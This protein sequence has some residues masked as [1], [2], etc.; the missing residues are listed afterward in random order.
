[1]AYNPY[2]P[3]GAPSSGANSS[4]SNPYISAA[5]AGQ[6]RRKKE[7]EDRQTKLYNAEALKK[8]DEKKKNDSK[9]I[10]DKAGSAIGNVAKGVGHFAHDAVMD[11][12][13]TT[14]D[15]WQGLGDV[16]RGELAGHEMEQ[17]TEQRNANTKEWS[18]YM[19]T[20]KTEDWKKPEVK[21]KLKEFSDK[22]KGIEVSQQ[23]KDDMA[24]EQ[25][26]DSKKLAFDTAQTFL[27]VA[28]AGVGDIIAAP[29]ELGAKMAIKTA[30]KD[31]I[32]TGGTEVLEQLIKEGGEQAAKHA[33][34]QLLKDGSKAAV[35][36]VGSKLLKSAGKDALLGSAF[37]VTST[38]SNNPNATAKDYIKAAAIG[39]VVGGAIPV[40][41]T[42]L[43]GAKTA[44]TER[45]ATKAA[46]RS[47]TSDVER[48]AKLTPEGYAKE[49]GVSVEAAKTEQAALATSG[50]E[51]VDKGIKAKVRNIFTPIKNLG[52]RTQSSFEKSAGGYHVAEAKARAV[53]AQIKDAAESAGVK[54]DMN[55][56]HDIEAGTAPKNA[57][58]QQFREIA[59]KAR[60]EGLDAGLDIGHRENYVPH[61]WKQ[62]AEQVDKIARGAG[63]K[64][65]AEGERIIPT[66][67]EGLKLGLKPKYTDPAKMMGEYVKNIE[68]T[69]TN[70]ALLT[71][72]KDQGLL[73]SG[74]PPAG[75]KTISA[76]GFPRT[77]QGNQLAAPRQMAHILDNLYGR[78][79]SIIDKALHKTAR[80]N[81]IWQDIALAGG[82]PHTPANFFTFS[83]AIKEAALGTGQVVTGS[84][85]QGA[86]TI[87]SPVAAFVRSFSDKQTGKVIKA[88]EGFLESLAK[89]GAPINFAET[90]VSRSTKEFARDAVRW[91]KLFNEPTFGRFMPNLQLNTAKNVQNALE[92]KLGREAALD[93]T[94]DIMKKMYGITD[95]LATGRSQAVQDAIGTVAFAPKYRESIVNVLANTVKSLNPA[96]YGDRAYSLNRRLAVGMGVTY[97]IYDQLNRLATGH[98]IGANP[99]GK[100]LQLA[101]PYGGKDD[102]GNQKVVYIP[103]MPSFMTLP[104]AAVGAVSGLVHGDE[105]AVTSEAGKLLSMPVQVISQLASNKDYFGRP[106]T[107]DE[108][109]SK[110]SGKPEDSFGQKWLKR[111]G[112]VAG[113]A[114][115]ALPRAGLNALEGKPLEQ[116]AATA[117]EAPVRFGTTSPL[118][119]KDHSYSP[120]Q[121]TNDWFKA[122]NPANN[123][124]RSTSAEVTRLVKEGKP[125][126][127]RRKAQ[128]FNDSL[129]DRFQKYYGK[130]G[131]NPSSD[132]MWDEML[133]SLSIKISDA[134]FAA[135]Y[136]Q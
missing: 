125:G 133:N 61:I 120:G 57:F 41:G 118:S 70:V 38:G 6:K 114:A 8:A 25:K 104:R 52:D 101:I 24:T 16:A 124:R 34:T 71:E 31:A 113:Q 39:G 20:L 93:A 111:A 131:Q 12:K 69:R 13:N 50:T 130:Y 68:N 14:V 136:K 79:D 21:A 29:L 54:L 37:G 46:A 109:E 43:K 117:L 1:M 64:A 72:L 90:G 17:K 66:Y 78:S 92:K 105:R 5:V 129:H 81:S 73:K 102:K 9:S 35:E 51:I 30:V 80:V 85:I 55:L 11:V 83:Q 115:P 28:T 48:I 45:A 60:Q 32:K 22:N 26:V 75:W 108:A 40:A 10:L 119:T 19:R 63:L 123:E 65:R 122:Y 47:L 59:D 94:A 128:E 106:I 15:T 53:T 127:A 84:P 91:D 2:L 107:I 76:E 86:K 132:K 88:N 103:F 87:F 58:T 74:R 33:A 36:S 110:A 82:I 4:S 27:T 7:E 116:N 95:Q 44:I 42:I 18:A 112:Y 96:T 56:V 100:E 134:G 121:V 89:R 23:S 77:A 99:D 67:E 97:L 3:D 49:F 126:E 62:S 135:R 98:S